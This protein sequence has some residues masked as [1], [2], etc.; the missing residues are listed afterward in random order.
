M[1]RVIPWVCLAGQGV[2]TGGALWLE[3]FWLAGC[4]GELGTLPGLFWWAGQ[5]SELGTHEDSFPSMQLHVP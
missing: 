4:S 1:S 3:V 5:F 2:P